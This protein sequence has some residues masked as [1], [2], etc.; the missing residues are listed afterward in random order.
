M[1]L[2]DRE[3]CSNSQYPIYLT[4]T[5]SIRTLSKTDLGTADSI[6]KSAFR[7]SD[8]WLSDLHLFREL[9]PEG[10]FLACQH[11]TPTG[12]VASIIYSN[13]AYAGLMG[14][15]REFQKQGIGLNLMRHLLA[16]LDQQGVQ[17]VLL[18]A[19]PVGQ[20]LYEKL[21]FMACDEVYVLQRQISQ[22]TFQRPTEVQFISEKNLDLI[23]ATDEPVFGAD[24]RRLLQVLLKINPERAFLLQDDDGR[25]SGYLIGQ[26]KRIGPWVMEDPA[27]AE[28]LLR[29]ALALPFRGPVSVVVPGKNTN[30]IA[31]FQ[32]HKFEIVRVNRHMILGLDVSPGQRE[33]I[34]AQASLSLG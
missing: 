17:Q 5:I 23:T 14:V 19:S 10:I 15:R 26:E 32:H 31:L 28:L 34:Y 9:H 25:L 29:A 18:D 27:K 33:K 30:A 13:F 24:R 16:W 6:L 7:R 21:N 2:S 12:M 4:V 22:P 1:V 3:K 11:N 8:S 20:S